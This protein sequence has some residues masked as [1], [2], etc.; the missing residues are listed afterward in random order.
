[1]KVIINSFLH[2]FKVPAKL[3][4]DAS[5]VKVLEAQRVLSDLNNKEWLTHGI[6]R[7]TW[8]FLLFWTIFPLFIWWKYTDRSR[9]LEISFFGLI[10]SLT[11][12][13]LDSV[14][15]HT[16]LWS[17]P[18]ALLPIPPNF[19]PIDY[20]TIPVIFMLVYQK[21][22]HW[23]GFVI[24]STVISS[25]LS[26]ILDPIIN[27]MNLYQPLS[28]HYYYS[29]PVFIIMVSFCKLITAIIVNQNTKG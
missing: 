28:W 19:F 8:W 23:K 26:L 2:G 27:W 14:G 29:I 25:F 18:D 6:H 10:V 16:L 1:M 7:W 21:Y 15:V 24:A 3:Y 4:W 5:Y 9:F 13:I 11:A 12:G 17:Y 22:P 20:I